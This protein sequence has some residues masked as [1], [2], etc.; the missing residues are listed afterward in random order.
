MTSSITDNAERKR[1]GINKLGRPRAIS[2]KGIT[3]QW[4]AQAC[5]R[6]EQRNAAAQP[7]WKCSSEHRH[8][9]GVT[10]PLTNE[11]YFVS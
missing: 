5:Q 6:A 2:L 3:A 8:G 11:Q 4:K 7:I 1:K 10:C 9:N